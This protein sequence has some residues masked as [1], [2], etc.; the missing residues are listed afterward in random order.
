MNTPVE[1]TVA[2]LVK[3][4][5]HDPDGDFAENAKEWGY[6]L[7]MGGVDCEEVRLL[8]SHEIVVPAEAPEDEGAEEVVIV[9]FFPVD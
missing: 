6:R 7:R 8:E 9:G 4:H 3:F 5:D 2:I 1:K